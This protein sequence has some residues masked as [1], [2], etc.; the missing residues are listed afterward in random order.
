MQTPINEISVADPD[1]IE[2][3]L[4][5]LDH[6]RLEAPYFKEVTDFLKESVKESPESLYQINVLLFSKIA[7]Y[8]G[9]ERPIRLFSEMNLDLQ[10]EKLDKTNW[11][12]AISK[13]VHAK[14]YIN[15]P[16]GMEFIHEEEFAKNG[17]KLTFQTFEN[18]VYDTGKVH[19]FEAGMSIIDVMMWNSPDQIKSYLDNWRMASHESSISDTHTIPHT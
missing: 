3:L 15:R 11:G 6:Y 2:K 17:I 4:R 16:G 18:M 8:L 13:K 12:I 5:Q 19:Q 14:E 1:W 7:S 10:E 9:I